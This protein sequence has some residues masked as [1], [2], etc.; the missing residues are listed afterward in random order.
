MLLRNLER[1]KT[2]IPLTLSAYQSGRNT[3]EQIFAFKILAEKAITSA[4]YKVT[5]LMLDMSKAFNK[6][7][8]RNL[9]EIL[10]EFLP[11]DEIHMMKIL[12]E[13]VNLRIRI[14]TEISEPFITNIRVPRETASDPSSS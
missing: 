1:L 5:L 12:I 6:V 8:R 7:K 4:D 10:R 11:P 3:A 9:V 2:K 14:G 13:D